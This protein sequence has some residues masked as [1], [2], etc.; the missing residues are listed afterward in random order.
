MMSVLLKHNVFFAFFF[1]IGKDCFYLHTAFGYEYTVVTNVEL[2]SLDILVM[3]FC[4]AL[5]H[6]AKI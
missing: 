6:L 2:T 5:A 1:G 4:S 3:S